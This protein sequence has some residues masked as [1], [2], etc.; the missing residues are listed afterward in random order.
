MKLFK[1]LW[2]PV[3]KLLCMRM[4]NILQIIFSAAEILVSG[5]CCPLKT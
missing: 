4:N 1:A 3:A 2:V 5:K